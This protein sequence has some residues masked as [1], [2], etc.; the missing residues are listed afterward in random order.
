MTVTTAQS[1]VRARRR[2][3]WVLEI[4]LV[5]VVALSVTGLVRAFIAQAFYI[6][7]QSM[8][9]TLVPDDWI[10]VSKVGLWFGDVERGDVVVFSDPG[11]WLDEQQPTPNVVRRGLE[12]IGVAPSSAEGDL[13]KRVIGVG[14]DRVTCCDAQ[15]RLMVNGQ[16]ID[17]TSVDPVDEPGDAPPG[18]LTDFD[19]TV[20]YDYL[21]VMG[22]HRS[23]SKDSRCQDGTDA[24]VPVDNVAGRAVA[25]FLP[26]GHRSLIDRPD[27][28]ALAPTSA[29]SPLPSR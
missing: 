28:Y 16:P 29:T 10:M 4:V 20:P 25:V 27:E 13:V 17:E 19:V 23:A 3:H 11:G 8:E 7:S 14:G 5:L 24:F 6:P 12:L 26:F 18:C 1:P 9:E 2:N 22:D 15:G 21:W